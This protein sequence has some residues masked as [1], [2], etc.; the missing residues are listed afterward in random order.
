MDLPSRIHERIHDGRAVPAAA[1]IVDDIDV[2]IVEVFAC[3][4]PVDTH[5]EEPGQVLALGAKRWDA[6][7]RL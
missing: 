3:V 5:L 1:G 6:Q 7:V 2:A 4:H